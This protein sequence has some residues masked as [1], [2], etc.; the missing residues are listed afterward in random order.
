M[1]RHSGILKLVTLLAVVTV[2]SGCG[3]GKDSILFTTKTSLGLDFDTKPMTVDIGYARKEGI[4]APVNEKGKVLPQMASFSA[5]VG[6]MNQAVGQS[7]ATGNASV[8]ISKYLTS[9]ARPGLDPIIPDK[10]IYDI[11]TIEYT[12]NERRYFFGT[13]T[14]V[15]LR[16]GFAPEQGAVVPDSVSF[17]Y[18]RKEVAF[19]PILFDKVKT[20]KVNVVQYDDN[21]SLVMKDNKPVTRE[22]TVRET[23]G[24]ARMALPALIATVGVDGD[25]KTLK[26]KQFYATGKAANNLAALPEIRAEIA[27]MMMANAKDAVQGVKAQLAV[28]DGI[29]REN[30]GRISKEEA[31]TAAFQ[32]QAWRQNSLIDEIRALKDEQAI[33]AETKLPD[34]TDM[35]LAKEQ[36]MTTP[37]VPGTTGVAAVPVSTVDLRRKVEGNAARKSLETRAIHYENQ[38]DFDRVESMVKAVKVK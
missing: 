12:G 5:N 15:A 7:I 14:A 1:S 24:Q 30:A 10:D 11:P 31:E 28:R 32:K 2:L 36:A 25:S 21:G 33:D 13:D 20:Q 29:K 3:F 8:L 27:P 35:V 19:V 6:V 37:G 26:L 4:I 18:K 38:D 34:P 22:I 16:I 9:P 17:G 23:G